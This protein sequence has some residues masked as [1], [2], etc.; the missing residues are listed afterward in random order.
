MPL[1]VRAA[2]AP[3]TCNPVATMLQLTCNLVASYRCADGETGKHSSLRGCRPSK[4]LRVRSP[5]CVPICTAGGIGRHASLRNWCPRG[6]EGSSPSP[7]TI[8]VQMMESV[9]LPVSKIGAERHAGSIPALHTIYALSS[10]GRAA[11]F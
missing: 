1:G 9:D 11:D 6:H 10:A 4:G 3:P 7:C 8:H 2:L 5:L